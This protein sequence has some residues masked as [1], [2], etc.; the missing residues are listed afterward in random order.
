MHGLKEALI[1][2]GLYPEARAPGVRWFLPC[3]QRANGP[4]GV[5]AWHAYP[6]ASLRLW[7]SITQ[8]HSAITFFRPRVRN[9]TKPLTLPQGETII[10]QSALGLIDA[11]DKELKAL[12]GEL[13]AQAKTMPQVRLLLGVPGLDVV[14]IM[15]ILAEIGDVQRFPSP[16]KLASY[17][18]L[19]PQVYASGKRHYTGDITTAGRSVLRWILIQAAHRAV[20]MPGPLQAFFRRLRSRK[21][22]KVAIS[23]PRPGNC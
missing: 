9:C 17:A 8:S 4:G 1:C 10:L 23:W 12:E 15:T 20:R 7:A 3:P 18:G 21:G 5:A 14:S 6:R 2:T 22:Y 19:V 11:L 16:K 13:C